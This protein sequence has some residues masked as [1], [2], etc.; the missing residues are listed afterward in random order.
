MMIVNSGGYYYI[1]HAL[2]T[3]K[4]NTSLKLWYNMGNSE[5]L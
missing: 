5:I 2:P 1:R 4:N 3:V